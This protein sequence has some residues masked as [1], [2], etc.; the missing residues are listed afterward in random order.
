[1]FEKNNN[2]RRH[3]SSL[4]TEITASLGHFCF[5]FWKFRD[6]EI[7]SLLLVG[8]HLIVSSCQFGIL[9]LMFSLPRRRAEEFMSL[10]VCP[11]AGVD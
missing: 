11:G 1:M 3:I 10:Y 9:M 5:S 6:K 4:S 2:P 8:N 7:L